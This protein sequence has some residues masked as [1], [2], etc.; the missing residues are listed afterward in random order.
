MRKTAHTVF[1]P[2]SFDCRNETR[3]FCTHSN[4]L[5]VNIVVFTI[6]TAMWPRIWHFCCGNTIPDIWWAVLFENLCFDESKNFRFPT[7]ARFCHA[8]VCDHLTKVQIFLF[9]FF[10]FWK[11]KCTKKEPG[12]WKT[13]MSPEK[14]SAFEKTLL[15]ILNCYLN[16]ARTV[17]NVNRLLL[18]RNWPQNTLTTFRQ[19]KC[20]ARPHAPQLI[21]VL[22]LQSQSRSRKA[23]RPHLTRGETPTW[24]GQCEGALS[25]TSVSLA[26]AQSG[27]LGGRSYTL[28]PKA[29]NTSL[30]LRKHF[31]TVQP[32]LWR[33]QGFV[34]TDH[35]MYLAKGVW[36]ETTENKK[37]IER[38]LHF[39]EMPLRNFRVQLTN[40]KAANGMWPHKPNLQNYLVLVGRNSKTLTKTAL[41]EENCPL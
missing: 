35:V 1:T 2:S 36:K 31:G 28:R 10:C 22:L 24:R 6:Q 9:R 25:M 38:C 7:S 15:E 41:P 5:F 13:S 29:F 23:T 20:F 37:R 34:T 18:G 3:E 14:S 27:S 40:F 11:Q 8:S 32:R 16:P 30:L 33:N 39:G 21:N 4:V 17:V 26:A 19:K 12:W